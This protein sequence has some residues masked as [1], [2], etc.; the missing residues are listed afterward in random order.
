MQTAPQNPLHAA[1]KATQKIL[2]QAEV[3]QPFT[4][5]MAATLKA[6]AEDPH[7]LMQRSL[8]LYQQH[9]ALG[10]S[11]MEQMMG[12]PTTPVAVP[13]KDDKRFAN[14]LWNEGMANA[15]KQS[16]LLTSK[17]ISDSVA[18]TE[19]KVDA[20][21]HRK[22]SFYTKLV[23]EMM[24]PGNNPFTNPE[25]MATAV[26]TNG[27][28][29]MKGME[30]FKKDMDA[31]RIS[32]T[33]YDDFTVGD[34]IG[35]TE[36]S[37]VFRNKLIEL[38]QYTPQTPKVGAI[39]LVICPP[40]INRF[41]I[42][43]LQA[44]NS[45]VNYLVGQGFQ[46]FMI[47]WKNPDAS[48]KDVTFDDYI[49][50][51]FIAATDAAMAI[52]GQPKVNALGYCIGG[53]MLGCATAILN[54]KGDTRVN[55][56]TFLNALMDYSDVGEIDVFLDDTQFAKLD[57]KMKD[58]GVLDGRDMAAAFSHLR[59][60]DLIWSYVINNYWL[61]NQP[62]P[63]D[64]LY[65]NDDSTRMPAAMHSW[66]LKNFYLENNIAKAG[67]LSLLGTPLDISNITQPAYML[68][69]QTDHITPWETCYAPFAKLKSPNKRFILSKSGH[70]AGVVN[71]P[72]AADKAGKRFL[73]AGPATTPTGQ[74]WLATATQVADSWWPDYAA[75]LMP[76]SGPQVSAPKTLGNTQFTVLEK[77][78]GGYVRER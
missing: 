3:T 41:Y 71:P 30:N 33:A 61:G 17:F 74:A 14:P 31:G 27:Q 47:S 40:W 78:P 67:K 23:L 36:G 37:V 50:H 18:S 35:C 28:S 70:V 45:L 57:A 7:A 25:V 76:L 12:Q 53:A 34:N 2:A 9:L 44:H 58:A 51:G 52:S 26:A 42:L 55:S 68:G 46:V 39:P 60:S 49:Q 54:T 10:A 1:Q 64:I 5:A 66:Y 16:Y 6:M 63:F 56:V 22:A 72:P 29:L 59:S 65:W 15:L 43:D 62:K 4:E 20:A 38:I 21:T 48:Y 13:E 32:M 77:A 24:S 19:G 8:T 73:Q 75:W 11:L 69:G